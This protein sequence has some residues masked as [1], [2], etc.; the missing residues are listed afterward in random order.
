LV[1]ILILAAGIGLRIAPPPA[2]QGIGFDEALYR[3]YL[4]KLDRVGLVDYP[5]V[6]AL[7][8]Q[9]QQRPDASAKLPPTRFLYIGCAAVWKNLFHRNTPA[10]DPRQP[11]F[12]DRDPY[13]VSLKSVS[14][15]FSILLLCLT[16]VCAWRML[17]HSMVIPAT[18][19]LACA[20]IPVHMAQHALIDGFFAFWATLALWL[21]WESIQ[22]PTPMRL[23]GLGASCAALVLAKENAFFVGTSLGALLLLG[24]RIGLKKP[25]GSVWLAC[26]TGTVLGLSGLA[27]LAGGF[28]TLWVI[29]NLL[30]TQ[31]SVLPYAIQTGDGPWHR[32]LLD[33]LTINPVL[34][35]LALA[36][37]LGTAW[38]TPATAYLVAFI[39]ISYL[40]MCNVRYGMNLRYTTIWD[41]PLCA[42]AA[43]QI[44][45]WAALFPRRVL[46]LQSVI[47]GIAC[48][49]ALH[50][51]HVLFIQHPLY[52]LASRGLLEA[53]KVLK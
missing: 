8:V 37:A 30:V 16:P 1:L 4:A 53:L 17:G 25:S 9:N 7:Y 3:D 15:L 2:F 38:R 11:R 12:A 46:L 31:A 50:L 27:L 51:Y 40:F 49:S 52:E 48:M 13:L 29:Y 28:D 47:L 39:G 6:C 21:L 20:P 43:F 10:A 5:E 22:H 26:G 34:F 41:F 36:A 14:A 42:L 18:A 19:L 23:L 33:L 24:A 32:Y 44:Q 45:H 35:C